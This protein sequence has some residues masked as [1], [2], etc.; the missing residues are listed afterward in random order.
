VSQ[1]PAGARNFGL[2]VLSIGGMTIRAGR[3]IRSRS[4]Y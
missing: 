1:V 4:G 2:T 3:S